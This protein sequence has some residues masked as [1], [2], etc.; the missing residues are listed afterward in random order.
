MRAEKR[1]LLFAQDDDCY[2]AT[3]KILLVAHVLVSG[4]QQVE[5]CAFGGTQQVAVD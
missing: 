4:Q 2:L 1:P 5:T 3:G